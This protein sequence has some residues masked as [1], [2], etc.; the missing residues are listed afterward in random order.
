MC[1]CVK[2]KVSSSVVG[3]PSK[4]KFSLF[5]ILIK[6]AAGSPVEACDFQKRLAPAGTFNIL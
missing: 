2:L 4:V 1:L 6:P 5:Q 3:R